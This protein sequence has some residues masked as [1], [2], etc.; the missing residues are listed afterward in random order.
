MFRCSRCGE[1]L[2]RENSIATSRKVLE[3]CKNCILKIPDSELENLSPVFLRKVK[4]YRRR[5]WKLQEAIE[6]SER[7]IQME[8]W[9]NSSLQ[10]VV[11]DSKGQF[12]SWSRKKKAKSKKKTTPRTFQ[13]EPYLWKEYESL[14]QD[15]GVL[16]CTY[17]RLIV[18]RE[19]SRLK[20]NLKIRNK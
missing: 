10:Q 20:E 2:T 8:T 14:C 18:T 9:K 19:I 16:P 3:V 11:R 13:I 15:Q 7:K 6:D 12:V 1:E 17:L 4:S 5:N